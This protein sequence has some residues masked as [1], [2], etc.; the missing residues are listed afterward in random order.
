MKKTTGMRKILVV[1]VLFVTAMMCT[2]CSRMEGN[3]ILPNSN[4]VT[5][6]NNAGRKWEAAQEAKKAAAAE[7][8]ERVVAAATKNSADNASVT[9]NSEAGR[10]TQLATSTQASEEEPTVYLPPEV[11]FDTSGNITVDREAGRATY[12]DG[13][14]TFSWDITKYYVTVPE[15]EPPMLMWITNGCEATFRVFRHEGIADD[16]TTYASN[17]IVKYLKLSDDPYWWARVYAV[18]V[19]TYFAE[20]GYFGIRTGYADTLYPK[21]ALDCDLLTAHSFSD[22]KNTALVTIRVNGFQKHVTEFEEKMF[23]DHEYQPVLE[24]LFEDVIASFSFSE[25]K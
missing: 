2:A 17:N 6:I 18:G 5:V 20:R 9:D 15:G 16:L 22:G 4:I 23:I 12:D 11:S 10:V 14:I 24:D 19:D 13:I 25:A 21:N 8:S 1:A 3:D 7:I